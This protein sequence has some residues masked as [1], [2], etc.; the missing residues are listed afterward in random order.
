MRPSHLQMYLTA[1]VS[2]NVGAGDVLIL[3]G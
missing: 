3:S 2:E 1:W